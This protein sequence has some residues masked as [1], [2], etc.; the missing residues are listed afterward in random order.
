MPGSSPSTPVARGQRRLV[1]LVIAAGALAAAVGSIVGLG[2]AVASLFESHG[3]RPAKVLQLRVQGVQSMT[4]GEWLESDVPGA[5]ATES[6]RDRSRPGKLISFHLDTAH[7]TT[8]DELAVRV[9]LYDLTHRTHKTFEVEPIIGGD[10]DSCGCT[11]WVP[12]PR[13]RTRYRARVLIF[14]PGKLKLGQQPVER[15][16]TPEFTG[17]TA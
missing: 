14:Q 3:P 17:S 9:I 2:G 10:G 13:G 12:V 1:Q 5:A 16:P 6:E 11:R 7:L 4:H 8:K 15:E